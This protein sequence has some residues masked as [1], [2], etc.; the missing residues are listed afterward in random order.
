M[1][2]N[3]GSSD[4]S[5][6]VAV[7]VVTDGAPWLSEALAALRRQDADLTVVAVDNASTDATPDLLAEAV[8]EAHR[9]RLSER[10]GF[11]RAVAAAVTRTV[12]G[13][14]DRLL[15]VHEDLL[16]APDATSA[17]S[18]ALDADASLGIVGCKLR[19]WSDEPVLVEFGQ[20]V[21]AFGRVESTL[22]PGEIDQGQHDEDRETFAVSTAGMMVR[23]RVLAEIGGFDARYE[24]FR[25]D[26]DLCWRARVAG[27]R[28]E[29]APEAVGYH[30]GAAS[31]GFRHLGRPSRAR[32]LAERHTVATALKNYRAS[33]VLGLLPVAVALGAAKILAFVALRRFAEAGAV[34][35]AY[36]WNL[37]QLPL[38]LRRRRRVQARRRVSDQRVTA[39]F[40]PGLPRLRTYGE[41][42]ASWVAGGTTRALPRED[43]DG[44]LDALAGWRA[45]A[46]WG[47]AHPAVVVGA[48]LAVVY[49]VGVAG[50][51]GPGVLRGATVAPWPDSPAAFFVAAFAPLESSAL[52]TGTIGSPA[53]AL[54]G[55][56][57]GLSLGNGWLASR[58]LVLGALP[59]AWLTALRAGRVLTLRPVPRVIGATLYAVSPAVVDPLADG[60]VGGLA[61]A[62]L[63]PAALALTVALVDAGD[64]AR[65]R[66]WH[67]GGLLVL[68]LAALGSLAPSALP[69]V[70]AG[71]V[72]AAGAGMTAGRRRAQVS[73][74]A[75]AVAAGVGPLVP[76]LVGLVQAG[77]AEAVPAGSLEPTAWWQAL[78]GMPGGAPMVGGAA[79]IATAV[80]VAAVAVAAV[81]TGL[82]QWPS[83]VAGLGLVAVGAGGLAWLATE[84]DITAVSPAALLIAA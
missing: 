30:L 37:A 13:R 44:A 84:L 67:T 20:T 24:L 17:L 61:V 77:W 11:G 35:R 16:L 10:V 55:V 64:D 43:A 23:R 66:V 19:G 65:A 50:L 28:V 29:V 59:V 1:S 22:E 12:A 14:A 21:D 73:R 71:L 78:T 51:L 9:L 53:P 80:A 31:G 4:T 72:L 6:L 46:R 52:A 36:A 39:L 5:E 62:A 82:R 57:S 18:A 70:A 40:V 7:L 54:L 32:E 48:L 26:L 49:A 81:A 2:S 34:T 38:T 41:A 79:G 68:T 76:W 47:V 83:V 58:L 15:L 60:R 45:W 63:L 69:V 74:L 8:P 75:V 42:I 27:W 56:L 25:E 3:A 33:R